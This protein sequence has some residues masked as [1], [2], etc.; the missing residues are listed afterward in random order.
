MKQQDRERV[1]ILYSQ[2]GSRAGQQ[3]EEARACHFSNKKAEPSVKVPC[4]LHLKLPF[5]PTHHKVVNGTR[6]CSDRDFLCFRNQYLLPSSC[7]CQK[8]MEHFLLK[9]TRVASYNFYSFHAFETIQLASYSFLFCIY[10]YTC[11]ACQFQSRSFKESCKS[12]TRIFL[13]NKSRL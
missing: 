1:S 8:F 6:C 13:T 3:E 11:F 5:Y 9:L 12:D 2:S 10:I 7:I 4:S